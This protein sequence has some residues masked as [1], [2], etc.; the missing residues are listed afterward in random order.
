MRLANYI[1]DKN[2]FQLAAPPEWWLKELWLYDSDAVIL[3]SRQEACFRLT[4]RSKRA[5]RLLSH[6][7]CHPLVK[8][9]PSPDTIMCAE[10]GVVPAL[11]LTPLNG[12]GY[13]LL[14]HI[15]ARDM[16]RV[17]GWKGA[18]RLLLQQEEKEKQ[19]KWNKVRDAIDEGAGEY[20]RRLVNLT[21]S[22]ASYA[23][24]EARPSQLKTDVK[25]LNH[26]MSPGN[27]PPAG[28]LGL[29]S[30]KLTN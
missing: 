8:A 26:E 21:G 10:Y 28:G 11:T 30:S 14:H 9:L 23:G 3:P 6:H 1:P 19:E 17:G 2:R 13:D 20:Y 12:W 16:W 24:L 5:P 4:R 29:P 18:E 22:R 15:I 7:H 27:R 25:P